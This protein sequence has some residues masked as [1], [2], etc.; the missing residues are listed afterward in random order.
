MKI[1]CNNFPFIFHS[2][3]DQKILAI[4]DVLYEHFMPSAKL[5]QQL[6]HDTSQSVKFAFIHQ[7]TMNLLQTLDTIPT[8]ILIACE[9]RIRNKCQIDDL[10]AKKAIIT[11]NRFEMLSKQIKHQF[12]ATATYRR[13]KLPLRRRCVTTIPK[14]I[15]KNFMQ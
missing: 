13:I 15:S 9:Q 12:T 4:I 1:F 2:P 11:Q 3:L 5:K 8:D 7:Y 14:I 6:L 10:H